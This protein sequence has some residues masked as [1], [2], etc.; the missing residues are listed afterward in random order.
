MTNLE[1][2][3]SGRV[4]S[5]PKSSRLTKMNSMFLLE[6]ILCL[7]DFWTHEAQ[8]NEIGKCGHVKI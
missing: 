6:Y 8:T 1:K 5:L 2:I 7:Y 3:I 4:S